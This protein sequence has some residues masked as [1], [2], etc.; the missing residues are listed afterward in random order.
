M[1]EDIKPLFKENFIPIVFACD[2]NYVSYLHT[3]LISLIEHCNKNKNYELNILQP[4]FSESSK[5]NILKLLK[6]ADNVKIRFI[7]MSDY[8]KPYLKY[9][10]KELSYRPTVQE[11]WLSIYYPIFF[12]NLFSNYNKM[13]FLDADLIFNIDAAELYEID[14][15]DKAVAGV[16]DFLLLSAVKSKVKLHG[17]YLSNYFHKHW[18][19]DMNN[20][21]N[22]GVYLFNPHKFKENKLLDKS[23]EILKKEFIFFPDQDLIN[24]ILKGK[25]K[26]LSARWNHTYACA[27]L[28]FRKWLGIEKWFADINN[29]LDIYIYHYPGKRFVQNQTSH[30]ELIFWEYAKKSIYYHD[31]VYKRLVKP[32]IGEL[33]GRLPQKR[34]S[35]TRKCK[36]ILYI[37][38]NFILKD[39]FSNKVIKYKY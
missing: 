18:N 31:L 23:L 28:N 3:T 17:Q 9:F 5:E 38:L 30:Q 15:E 34:K 14:L 10:D 27:D 35:I 8:I 32:A 4:D 11:S 26:Y 20:Y 19:L 16:V 37:V 22:T 21:I 25:I 6:N 12:E 33:E 24:I 13:L 1:F 29:I 2:N 39:K 36:Y 7:D